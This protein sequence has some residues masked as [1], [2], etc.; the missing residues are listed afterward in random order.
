MSFQLD[1]GIRVAIAHLFTLEQWPCAHVRLFA[2]WL[3]AHDADRDVYQKLKQS[4]VDD[5][6][7]GPAYTA[8]KTNF[9]VSIVNQARA[10]MALPPV[11]DL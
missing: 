9:V 8:A 11:H 6:I 1:G 7:W 2:A 4:L 5:G 3:R 10:Q